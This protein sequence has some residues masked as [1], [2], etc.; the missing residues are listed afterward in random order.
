MKADSGQWIDHIWRMSG[1]K[2]E[3]NCVLNS[4]TEGTLECHV[5]TQD[6]PL[7]PAVPAH[8]LDLRPKALQVLQRKHTN[9]QT[10]E[11]NYDEHI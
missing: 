10:Y 1:E 4:I 7:R 6:E 5:R 11:I 3:W 9:R 8:A 2:Y